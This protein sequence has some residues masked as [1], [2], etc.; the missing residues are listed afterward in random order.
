[1]TPAATAL[2]RPTTAPPRGAPHHR[3]RRR[4]EP[5]A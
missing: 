5:P 2:P 1:M 4:G 3:H